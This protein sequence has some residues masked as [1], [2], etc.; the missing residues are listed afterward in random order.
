VIITSNL[1]SEVPKLPA[2]EFYIGA[3]QRG[4]A[5]RFEIPA[6]SYIDAKSEAKE[7]PRPPAYEFYM[8]I[9]NKE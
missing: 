2:Y 6:K 7:S 1:D 3:F 5:I 4:A 8:C 9:N